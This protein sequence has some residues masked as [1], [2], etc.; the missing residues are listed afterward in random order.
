MTA[1]LTL[2]GAVALLFV[3]WAAEAAAHDPGVSRGEYVLADGKLYAAVSFARRE[4][5]DAMPWLRG[6]DDAASVLAFEEH[7]DQLGRWLVEG[8]VAS[9]A[10]GSCPAKFDGLRFDGDGVALALSYACPLGATQVDFDVRFTSALARGH[11][12]LVAFEVGDDR[13]EAVASSAQ[14]VVSF[15]W[16]PSSARSGEP[17]RRLFAPLLRMG[18][19]HI[20]TGYDHL[21]FLLGLVLIGG[22][23]RSL[24]GAIT[25]FTAAHSITLA[26]AALGVWVPSP[27]FVE[28]CIALSIAY[29]GVENWFARDATGRWR[30]TFPFGLVHGFGFAGALSEIA[31]SRA[32]IPTALFAFNLGVE[33]AQIA[34]LAVVVPLVLVMHKKGVWGH[35]AMRVCTAAIALAGALWFVAR[36]R[37]SV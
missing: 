32:E 13:F 14:P 18:V 25:A 21:L 5:A 9:T 15:A 34:V 3:T 31:L 26:L 33:L 7:T 16:G 30:I 6:A 8:L 2:F 10:Q 23:V 17:A 36:L 24:V 4:L 29:V 27:R 28:A 35:G 22:P 20:L 1:R 11:R 37:T 12:H 19:E